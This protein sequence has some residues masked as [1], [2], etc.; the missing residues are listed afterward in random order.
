MAGR[1]LDAVLSLLDR[2]VS[3]P[4]GR[5]VCKVD[6]LE[7]FEPADGGAPYVTAILA[8][9]AAVGARLGGLLGRW[10]IAVQRRLHPDVDPRPARIDFGVVQEIK[11]GITVSLRREQLEPNRFEAWTRDNMIDKIPGA[12]HETQ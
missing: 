6:D 1:E 12:R 2:Q 7:L 11:T 10:F 4:D 5:L 8:G 3:D 9:P